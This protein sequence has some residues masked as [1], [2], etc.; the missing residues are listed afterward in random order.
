MKLAR[1]DIPSPKLLDSW[2]FIDSISFNLHGYPASI[3][4][5]RNLRPRE[6]SYAGLHRARA[7]CGVVWGL[8]SCISVC[9]QNRPDF[10]LIPLKVQLFFSCGLFFQWQECGLGAP[11][12]AGAVRPSLWWSHQPGLLALLTWDPS[13]TF[14]WHPRGFSGF[15]KS[16]WFFKYLNF[17][18]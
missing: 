5:M 8:F 4:E 18:T 14:L 7:R 11:R 3:L 17:K 12:C 13:Q 2:H 9:F 16:K 10:I 6:I 1:Q 15:L